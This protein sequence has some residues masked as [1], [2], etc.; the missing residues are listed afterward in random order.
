MGEVGLV[1]VV[2]CYC[3]VL[4]SVAMCDPSSVGVAVLCC[5]PPF[6]AV[7]V[8]GGVAGVVTGIG[9]VGVQCTVRT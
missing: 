2:A 4:V 8:V 9:V 1:V 5:V 7:S 6:L 3:V